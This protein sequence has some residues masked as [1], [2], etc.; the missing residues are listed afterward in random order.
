[1]K[2]S[3]CLFY[4]LLS[5]L[6]VSA[7]VNLDSLRN[8]WNDEAAEKPLRIEAFQEFI[9]YGYL[10]SKPDSAFILAQA[11]YDFAGDNGLEKQMAMAL[12]IQG[13]SFLVRG[14]YETALDYYQRSLEIL[15]G[16]NDRQAMA[17]TLNN[18]G[19]IY[20]NLGD[21]TKSLVYHQRSLDIKE[22]ISDTS[23]MAGSMNNIGLINMNLGNYPVALGYFERSLKIKEFYNDKRGIAQTLNNIGLIYMRQ[24]DY[25]NAL[26]Y[27]R[28]SFNLC[29]EIGD[30]QG[31]SGILTNIGLI[32]SRQKEYEKALDYFLKGIDIQQDI[33]DK[34]GIGTTLNNIGEVYLNKGNY[35]MAMDYFMQSLDIYRE[36]G[37]KTGLA[38]I[39]TNIGNLFNRQGDFNTGTSWCK[40]GL[41]IAEEINILDMQK[42]ACECLYD[43]YKAMKNSSQALVYHERI[44]ALNDNL[45]AEETARKLQQMEFERQMLADSLIREKEKLSIRMAHDEEVRRKN[46]VR[47]IFII[48]AVSL[49]AGIVLLYWRFMFVRKAKKAIETEKDRSDGLLLNIL[50]AEIAE[51]LKEKGRADARKFEQVT[52]LFTDFKGFTRISEKLSP[53]ELVREINICFES[54]DAICKKY[55]IEKIKTIGDSYMAAG[56]LPIPSDNSA[57]K[58]VLAGIEM[59]AFMCKLRQDQQARGKPLFEM[60]VGIHTGPVVAGIVGVSKFQY[61]VWG[62]SVNTASRVE[63][64]C[65]TC[66]VTI[67]QSTYEFI[68]DDPGFTFHYR[69]KIQTK[70]KGEIEMWY[71]DQV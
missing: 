7:Q 30:K 23:G 4:F 28:R 69:G 60:R 59:Q 20:S 57:R 3:L 35:T 67:S 15:E 6:L 66:R 18:I 43:A 37:D 33:Q 65:E 62:D 49:F 50:P 44:T 38:S 39:S 26:Q 24:T 34:K 45:R 53:E 42:D 40:K 71:V 47:N 41:L 58:T 21:F 9:K 29:E 8:I 14:N 16:M 63:N 68:K 64:T 27:F 22:D 54:F 25:P 70:G 19:V 31:S 51:E 36:I 32:Y 11:M 46:R 55:N 5:G 61:D 17:N 12:S 13:G 52:I 56:G 2:K 48:S 1:M 10:Y